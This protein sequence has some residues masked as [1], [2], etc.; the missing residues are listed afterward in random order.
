MAHVSCHCCR[1]FLLEKLFELLLQQPVKDRVGD[2]GAFHTVI[3]S[4]HVLPIELFNI[5][6]TMIDGDDS[7]F[8][9]PIS[10]RDVATILAGSAV[11][12]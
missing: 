12:K 7:H 9:A 4:L 10:R 11:G 3:E 1:G 8:L 5:L 2:I 6:M